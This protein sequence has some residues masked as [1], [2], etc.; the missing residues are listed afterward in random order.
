MD[1]KVGNKVDGR[2]KG[3]SMAAFEFVLQLRKIEGSRHRVSASYGKA[4]RREP[5][6]RYPKPYA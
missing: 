2:I 1:S 5:S 6:I 3:P 4:R